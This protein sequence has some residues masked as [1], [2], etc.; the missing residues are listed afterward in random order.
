MTAKEIFTAAI[1]L[2]V[3]QRAIFIAEQCG[4]DAALRASVEALVASHESSSDFF[5]APT[6]DPSTA[7][8]AQAPTSIHPQRIGPYKIL[9]TLGE[10]GFGTVYMAE[11]EQPVRR[12]VALKVIKLGMDTRQVIARFEA[13]RQALAIM[14]H[15]NIAR[16]FDAGATESGRPYFVMELVK[17][18]PVTTYC[19]ENKLTPRQRL[20]LFIPICQA[21]QHAHQ[22]GVLH[23]D[24]KPSNV[25]V[26]IHDNKPV[27]KVIDF[28]VAKATQA[29]LTEKTLFTEFRQMIGTPEYMSPEQAEMSGLDIDT[30]TDVYSLGV[31]LYELLTGLTPFDGRELRSKAYAEMQRIIREVDPPAPSTRISTNDKLPSLA[32]QRGIE[33]RK[34]TSTVRGELDWIVM[35]CLEKDRTRRYDSPS[36]LATDLKHFLADEPVA[37]SPPS[38]VYNLRK[39]V[40]RNRGLVTAV[41]TVFAVLLAGAVVSTI[42]AVIANRERRNANQQA[43]IAVAVSKFQS[44]ML[45][46][47]DP[48]QLLGDK[49]TVVQTMEAAIKKLDAGQL[50]DQPAVEGYLRDTIGNTLRTLGRYDLAEPNLRKAVEL[51]R[52]AL[53]PGHQD[54]SSSINNLAVLLQ[55]Q[56]K[57]AQAEPLYRE[58]LAISRKSTPP[59]ENEIATNLNNLATVLHAQGKLSEA[60]PVY[61]EAVAIRRRIAPGEPDL[62]GVLNN[63]AFVLQTEGKSNEA[64]PLLR[65][66]L[67][68]WR[69]KLGPNHPNLAYT[70]LNLGNISQETGKLDEAEKQFREALAIC[71]KSLPAD[72]PNIANALSNLAWLLKAQGRYAE[73]EKVIR[74]AMEMDQKLLSPQHPLIADHLH[75]LGSVLQDEDRLPEA[76]QLYRQAIAIQRKALP[77]PHPD[78]AISLNDL[79]SVL[80]EQTKFAEAEPISREALAIRR[81]VFPAGGPDIAASLS[82]LG[83]L[84]RDMGRT[85]EAEPLFREALDSFQKT[86]GKDHWRVGNSKFGLGKLLVTQKKYAEAE[87]ML[88]EA[89]RVLA[90]AP[91]APPGRHDQSLAALVTLYVSWDQ[92]DAGKGYAVKAQQW[93]A[94]LP[95]T[96]PSTQSATRPATTQS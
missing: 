40:R 42:F 28:G 77:S 9:Q 31:L 88:L 37:A 8:V 15:P 4:D 5:S 33:P 79:A 81:Q 32:A 39:F 23:R 53:A 70:L 25:L 74:E 21:V 65:E 35:K 64:E 96:G 48:D 59:L 55:A 68:I 94:K 16:V 26:T 72:H 54:T 19:D 45:A 29:R 41:A 51:R 92:A 60:E 50:K 80:R 95:A 75:S 89:E 36:A 52:A 13:E 66:A 20:D 69:D 10:G 27:P 38:T 86:Y 87:P 44:D 58:A 62:A 90:T 83:F 7:T 63:L 85:D 93:K 46:S 47:A 61:R 76:E 22:K 84:L 43:A 34:L 18:V 12:T 11:Q 3:E 24:I 1:E 49:V 91:G 56:G 6:M 14:D 57:Y 73:A 17:G 82:N 2:P 30:R 67:A 78:L 71:R